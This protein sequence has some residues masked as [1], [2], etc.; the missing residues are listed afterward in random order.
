MLGHERCERGLIN[1]A[2]QGFQPGVHQRRIVALSAATRVL[3]QPRLR[4]NWL[5]YG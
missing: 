4:Q 5:D 3:L 1:P 2:S